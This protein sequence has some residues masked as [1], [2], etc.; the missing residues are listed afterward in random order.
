MQLN[1]DSFTPY[2]SKSFHNF[3]RVHPGRS[4][5]QRHIRNYR[6]CSSGI[7]NARFLLGV[8][9]SLLQSPIFDLLGNPV[10]LQTNTTV[11]TYTTNNVSLKSLGPR[12]ATDRYGAT[13]YP[14]SIVI[15]DPNTNS[16]AVLTLPDIAFPPLSLTLVGQNLNQK[17]TISDSNLPSPATIDFYGEDAN[18]QLIGTTPAA[19]VPTATQANSTPYTA[20]TSV[21]NLGT[22]PLNAA[23]I[24]TFVDSPF[25]DPT[26]NEGIVA[27][28]AIIGMTSAAISSN[29]NNV[30][31]TYEISG[32]NLAS[33]GTIDFYW[34]TGPS[35]SDAIGTTPAKVKSATAVGSYTATTSLASLGAEPANASYIL[36]VADSPSADPDHDVSS[37]ELAPTQLQITSK[38]LTVVGLGSPFDVQVSAEYANGMVDK[39]FSGPVTIALDHNPTT[40]STLSRA[41]GNTFTVNA[42]NGV[43]DFPDLILSMAG[44]SYTLKGMSAGLSS[45]DT[46]PFTV[47]YKPAQ[48]LKAYGFDQ[49]LPL[50]D[51]TVLD[52]HG[53]TIAIVIPYDD[54]LIESDLN[55]F[56]TAFGLPAPPSFQK[57]DQRGHVIDGVN[58]LP[59]SV[60]PHWN[61]D[62]EEASEDVEWTH[63][64]APGANI[65]LMECDNALD[66][67]LV[68]SANMAANLR[69]VSVVVMSLAWPE[70]QHETTPLNS[71]PP[72]DAS[73]D[74]GVPNGVTFVAASGDF[75]SPEYPAIS[76]YV[77]AVGGTTLT[78]NANGTFNETGWTA[79]SDPS[80]P[81]QASGGG[82]SQYEREPPFQQGVQQSG[83]R[84]SPD[85]SFDADP[86]HRGPG[87]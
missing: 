22:Q 52:G 67:N 78:P 71:V 9:R 51:G 37:V 26:Y 49:I 61:D 18:G 79:G 31:A 64:I 81:S 5:H 42:V 76:P 80:A 20:T 63:A 34:A 3:C 57:V 62:E 84:T 28:P 27:A 19:A 66:Q 15:Y 83:R 58:F 72:Y 77:L 11:G 16:D 2:Y 24:V 12:P 44:T 54:P 1:Q 59:P 8:Y 41:S 30:N 21:G 36:A 23:F 50:P 82:Y 35:L 85:V 45:T 25:A 65:I 6:L 60:E 75:G 10:S 69:G 40:G 33:A 14:N 29:G 47:A 39:S 53:Q 55:A 87:V 74:S 86:V 73:F 68:E 46:I 38:P 17:Y 7:D 4:E 43:A 32:R 13:T 70:D 56:D 48:I